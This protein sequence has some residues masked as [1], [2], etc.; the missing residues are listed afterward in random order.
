[1]LG[2]DPGDL[3]SGRFSAG[4]GGIFA[5]RPSCSALDLE[6]QAG[7]VD[8]AFDQKVSHRGTGGPDTAGQVRHLALQADRAF[9][10]HLRRRSVAGIAIAAYRDPDLAVIG[11]EADK[12]DVVETGLALL[13]RRPLARLWSAGTAHF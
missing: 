2:V 3:F 6:R 12:Q 9:R 11:G 5:M 1:M 4:H 8:E 7:V 13:L 10:N